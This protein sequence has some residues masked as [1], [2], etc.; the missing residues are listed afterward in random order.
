[1]KNKQIRELRE[2]R[3]SARG[4]RSHPIIIMLSER[5]H[6]LSLRQELDGIIEE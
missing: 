6:I 1:M 2:K 5:K 3:D 4:Q